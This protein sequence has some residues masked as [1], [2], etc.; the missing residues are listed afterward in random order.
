MY[1]DFQPVCLDA[2][3]ALQGFVRRFLPYS[4]FNVWN[5]LG[6]DTLG[7]TSYA[8]LNNN[9]IVRSKDYFTENTVYSLL[10]EKNI[11]STLQ[12]LSGIATCFEFVPGIVIQN[13]Q[14][15]HRFIIEEDLDN[16]DY[17]L[18][19]EKLLNP[20]GNKLYSIR[21]EINRF[22]ERYPDHAIKVLDFGERKV[23][24]EVIEMTRAWG[25]NRGFR[26]D[27]IEDDAEITRRFM[28]YAPDFQSLSLG[29]YVGAKLIGITISEVLDG[30]TALMHIGKSDLTYEGSSKYMM[31][32]TARF[33]HQLGRHFLNYEQD[34]GVPGLR[35]AKRAYRPVCML[36]K[37]KIHL[38][39]G[40]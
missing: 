2:K 35:S 20:C 25:Q 13:I 32:I 12:G 27:E 6:W 18:S 26:E 39:Q 33:L 16:H 1:P 21:V 24:Q 7:E 9:L 11:D 29:L 5:L 37:Y 10:G 30:D 15:P 23:R 14:D 3:P 34:A 40:G 38:R 4:D 31:H 19:I 8:F 28:H 17:I 36:K 22:P